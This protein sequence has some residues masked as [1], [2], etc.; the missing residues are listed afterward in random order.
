MKVPLRGLN[1][2][3]ADV[4]RHDQTHYRFSAVINDGA[5][6]PLIVHECTLVGPTRYGDFLVF[7]PSR[8]DSSSN[9]LLE[10]VKLPLR[11]RQ[12]L[13]ELAVASREAELRAMEGAL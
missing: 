6:D 5:G 2:R 11:V 4:E 13:L 10:L 3:I 7:G 12:E 8:F 9:R 1:G